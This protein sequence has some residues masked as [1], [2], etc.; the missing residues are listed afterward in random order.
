MKLGSVARCVRRPTTPGII[1][2]AQSRPRCRMPANRR[3]LVNMLVFMIV[4]SGCA[5]GVEHRQ[6][7]IVNENRIEQPISRYACNERKKA[8]TPQP[9]SEPQLPA[10][11]AAFEQESKTLKKEVGRGLPIAAA[12]RKREYNLVQDPGYDEDQVAPRLVNTIM[13]MLE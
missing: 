3:R 7:D 11:P 13:R 4:S 8:P 6:N 10:K 5:D 9:R 1:K 12:S 2:P